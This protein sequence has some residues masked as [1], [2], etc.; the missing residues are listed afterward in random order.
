MESIIEG[1]NYDVFISYRQKDNRYD[2]WV[3]TFVDN[4]RREL[5][6]T[7]KEDISIYFDE[8][9]HDG[10]LETHNVEKSLEDKLKCLVFIPIISQTYCD[11]KSFAWQ[12]EFC[13]F[14]KIAK[15]DK[16]GLDI[17]LTGGNVAN[18][19]LPVKINDLDQ[20]DMVIIEDELGGPM[21]AID[22]IYKEPGVNRPL[23]PD[24]DEKINLNKT[25][26][27]NQINKVANAVKE[28]IKGLQYPGVR[29]HPERTKITE[30]ETGLRKGIWVKITAATS[31]LAMLLIAWFLLF[32]NLT[33]RRSGISPAIGKTIAVIPFN[34]LSNDH[35]QD[36]FSEGLVEEIQDRIC[37]IGDLKV[38]SRTSSSKYK[39]TKLTS[40]EI[41]HEI[42]ASAILEGTVQKNGNQI[43]ITAQLIDAKSDTQLWS[44]I[45][46]KDYADIFSIYS[47]VAQAIARE[48]KAVIT[49]ETQQFIEKRSTANMS[50]YDA[51]LKG[52]YYW[53]KLTKEDLETAMQY[54]ELAKEKDPEYALAYAGICD[55]WIGRQQMGIIMPAEAGL[56][57]EAA[58]MRALEL[59]STQSEVYYSLALMKTWGKFDWKGGEYA[60]RKA[61]ALNS[62]YA[63]AHAYYSHLL[64]ITGRQEEAM[65][66]IQMA[67]SLDPINPLIKSLYGVDLFFNKRYDEAVRIF[68]ETLKMDPTAPVARGNLPDALH[69][70]GRDI[71]AL[72]T[73]KRLAKVPEVKEACNYGIANSDYA[74]TKRKIGDIF[75]EKSK[76]AYIEPT[77]MAANYAM[78][79]DKDKA[80]DWLEKAYLD[81]SPDLPYL[82]LPYYDNL[83]D[84]PRFKE[85]CLK[86][87]LP[88]KSAS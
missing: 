3:T 75:M 84:E 43:R 22:F 16:F 82:L 50:A 56:K 37:R 67:L 45:F 12:H 49:P 41:A 15:K 1:F 42:G 13:A 32:P 4:L 34:N 11:T 19:I 10:L 47:E 71:D 64:N 58:A 38:I 79:G 81:R 39:N 28:I 25:R 61:I 66:Q 26:Y 51:Y 83:R 20:E 44:K 8:N 72:E 86:M 48:L 36:Y 63:E 29:V 30:G 73:L 70:A 57:G 35:D 5:E 33:K 76:S 2:G 60:F 17:R 31:I 85:L 65:I 80:I 7:F 27:R 62:N 9:P 24:D 46:D 74:G 14:N 21:R 53:S 55:V 88:V 23:T 40:K 77:I 87:N 52:R 18:R 69:F 78:A 54:F 6:A 68:Q 59:D